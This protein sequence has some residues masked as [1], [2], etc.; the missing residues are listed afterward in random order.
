[1]LIRGP[2]HQL[3]MSL[4]TDREEDKMSNKTRII[5]R[6]LATNF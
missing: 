5:R 3:V 2:T 6:I 4:K 1:M